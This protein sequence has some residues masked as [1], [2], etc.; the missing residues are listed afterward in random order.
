MSNPFNAV[1]AVSEALQTYLMANVT[2]LT[3]LTEWPNANDKLAYPT[4]TIFS[5]NPTLRNTAPE[6]LAWTDPDESDHTSTTTE[7]VGW[8]D[9]KIQLDV[10]CRNKLER[11]QYLGL[12]MAALNS[13]ALAL[14]G[15]SAP[16]GLSLQLTT[17]YNEWVSYSIDGFKYMD[18]EAAAQRQERRAKIDLLVNCR[19][20]QQRVVYG[21]T[22]IEAH[23]GTDDTGQVLADNVT[24]TEELDIP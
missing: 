13:Q 21:M 2:G 3:V 5:G 23:L 11:E 14:S 19:I 20:I 6:V 8:L 7:V 24:D 10:W 16:T 1:Q 17:Y 12:I 18:D 9:F 15:N 22:S 4:A